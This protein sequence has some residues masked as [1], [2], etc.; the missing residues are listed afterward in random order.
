MKSLI[1][2]CFRESYK[3]LIDYLEK[4][5]KIYLGKGFLKNFC[6]KVKIGR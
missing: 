3:F 2:K 1:V 5:V 6:L 4:L